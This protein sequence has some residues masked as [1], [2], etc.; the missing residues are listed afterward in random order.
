MA[1]YHAFR[2]VRSVFWQEFAFTLKISSSQT[3][4]HFTLTVKSTVLFRVDNN[5][6]PVAVFAYSA[7]C[8]QVA[9][10]GRVLGQVGG[11]VHFFPLELFSK[12]ILS[13]ES[14]FA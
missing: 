12:P 14:E 6:H 1:K 3:L 13:G 2:G 10:E 11:K 4:Q 5:V 7:C 9:A 8:N